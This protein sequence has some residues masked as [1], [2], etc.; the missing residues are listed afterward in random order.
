MKKLLAAGLLIPLVACAGRIPD[1]I[2]V[3]QGADFGLPCVAIDA[4]MAGNR[5]KSR[6]LAER[7]FESTAQNIG[8]AHQ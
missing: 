2:Q 3:E 8:V 6:Q 7:Q 5:A 1:P 4:E